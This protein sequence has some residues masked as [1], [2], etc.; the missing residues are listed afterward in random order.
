MH[1]VEVIPRRQGRFKLPSNWII[2][3][4]LFVY[5]RSEVAMHK[6]SSGF[7]P[8]LLKPFHHNAKFNTNLSAL[9][10][11]QNSTYLDR[12]I[13]S[14]ASP[15]TVTMVEV[16]FLAS[17]V[18]TFLY[19]NAA[20]IAASSLGSSSL[21]DNPTVAS[22][23][24]A[25]AHIMHSVWKDGTHAVNGEA[26]TR[27]VSDTLTQTSVTIAS[28]MGTNHSSTERKTVTMTP[29]LRITST[30]YTTTYPTIWTIVD[31]ETTTSHSS[32][33]S[34]AEDT[35]K[36]ATNFKDDLMAI[37]KIIKPYVSGTYLWITNKIKEL[38]NWLKQI[39]IDKLSALLVQTLSVM[40]VVILPLLATVALCKILYNFL[41]N[42]Q[43][44]MSEA[45]KLRH[46]TLGS[47]SKEELKNQVLMMQDLSFSHGERFNKEVAEKRAL[48]DE[49]IAWRL[50]HELLQECATLRQQLIQCNAEKTALQD[51]RPVPTTEYEEDEE[52]EQPGAASKVDKG[53]G[54]VQNE[55]ANNMILAANTE[56]VGTID[57]HQ[58]PPIDQNTTQSNYIKYLEAKLK[59][60]ENKTKSVENERD[61]CNTNVKVMNNEINDLNDHIAFLQL[62]SDNGQPVREGDSATDRREE[63]TE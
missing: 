27:T 42:M 13:S 16:D 6:T 26:S 46:S 33:K 24:S 57:A 52:D 63:G 32:A 18:F 56:N 62:T 35:N 51:G 12:L 41:H 4:G 49:V 25:T 48:R 38:T 5:Y 50:Q 7:H 15:P 53:K 37:C 14:Y 11:T 20:G 44:T 22:G 40:V 23:E 60:S 17:I 58:A 10:D 29:T 8:D 21:L 47:L 39:P 34:T 28:G 45:D 9:S 54:P 31:S 30:H 3:L 43:P 59:E 2:V 36:S 55:Q 1:G 19:A 61:E